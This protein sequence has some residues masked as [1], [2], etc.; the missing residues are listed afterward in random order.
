MAI[1]HRQTPRIQLPADFGLGLAV[2][3]VLGGIVLLLAVAGSALS[4][5][6][7]R[8]ESRTPDGAG[9]YT[10]IAPANQPVSVLPTP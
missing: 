7:P 3:T 6:G 9:T 1:L 5:S 2:T 8:A 10:D 4:G